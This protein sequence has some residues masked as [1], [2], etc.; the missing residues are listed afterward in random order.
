MLE[1]YKAAT[2]KRE[3]FWEQSYPNANMVRCMLET[4]QCMGSF[5]KFGIFIKPT[6]IFE[7][8]SLQDTL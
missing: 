5:D 8:L 1:L 4:G 2:G 7:L 3:L 6:T